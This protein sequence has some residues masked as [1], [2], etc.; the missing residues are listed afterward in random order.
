MDLRHGDDRGGA[1]KLTAE[2]GGRVA[3]Y[4]SII[5]RANPNRAKR[6]LGRLRRLAVQYRPDVVQ[7]GEDLLRTDGMQQILNRGSEEA[8]QFVTQAT[9]G[10]DDA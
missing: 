6:I 3:F 10:G 2:D 5:E 4:L 8:E 9:L 1:D 7:R